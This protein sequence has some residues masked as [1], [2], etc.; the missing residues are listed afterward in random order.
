MVTPFIFSFSYGS[1]SQRS[2]Y[3][4]STRLWKKRGF[5]IIGNAKRFASPGG[6]EKT[7]TSRLANATLVPAARRRLR[8][9][10]RFLTGGPS[11]CKSKR[12]SQVSAAPAMRLLIQHC[13]KWHSPAKQ[14]HINAI[15]YFGFTEKMVLLRQQN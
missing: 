11:Q 10:S 9:A 1:H 8:G 13:L 14:T 15:S 3:I 6:K 12:S 5:S 7:Q 2:K 4:E